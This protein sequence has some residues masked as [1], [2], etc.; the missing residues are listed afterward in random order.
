[1]LICYDLKDAYAAGC[2]GLPVEVVR[3]MGIDVLDLE[4]FPEHNCVIMAVDKLPEQLPKFITLVPHNIAPT[5]KIERVYTL[6]VSWSPPK[7]FYKQ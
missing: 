1:M 7:Y 6:Q 2:K 4:D 3:K 5:G